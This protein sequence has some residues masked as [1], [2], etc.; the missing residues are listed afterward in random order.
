MVKLLLDVGNSR[1]KC[2][3]YHNGQLRTFPPMVIDQE[4]VASCIPTQVKK[5]VNLIAVAS[6]R[7][8]DFNYSLSKEL[9]SY[10]KAL[11]VFVIAERS[12]C[13]VTSSYRCISSLGIDR[14]LALIG[15]WHR[16]EG[17]CIIAD[18][19]TAVTID[20]INKN[21]VH[22]GGL[23]MPG[24]SLLKTML[25]NG[26]DQLPKFDETEKGVF[27]TIFSRD[28]EGGIINGCQR[29]FKVAVIKA[30]CEMQKHLTGEAVLFATGG[31]G[32]KLLDRDDAYIEYCPHLVLEGL[33]IFSNSD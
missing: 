31:D 12:A 16:S 21:G 33:A 4:D 5:E 18:C 25:N 30:M 1:C 32:D 8:S 23:I 28:T 7:N 29:M 27:D 14:F 15:A 3:E 20:A 11:P 9:K 24:L 10:F 2:A 6:V 19:G 22:Q 17:A 26:T 13:G